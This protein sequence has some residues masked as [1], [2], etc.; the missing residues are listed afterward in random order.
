MIVRGGDDGGDA[1]KVR[2]YGPELSIC[3][4]PTRN[5]SQRLNLAWLDARYRN[6][7]NGGSSGQSFPGNDTEF[8]PYRNIDTSVEHHWPVEGGE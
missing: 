2:T 3:A 1:A 8:A 5:L 4:V 6:F 7:S